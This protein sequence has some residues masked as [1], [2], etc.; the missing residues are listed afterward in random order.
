MKIVDVGSGQ[1][2]VLIP[3][4]QGRWEWMRPAVDALAAR[5]RVVTYSLA[6]EPS[7]GCACRPDDGFD[8]YVEQVSEAMDAAGLRQASICGVSYGG[9]V[10]AAFAARHPDRTSSLVLVSALPPG[11]RPDPRVR[12]YLR[13]PRLLAPL[14]ML[15]SLRLYRE[16]SAARDGIL[17]GLA[18]GVRHGFNVLAHMFSPSRMARRIAMLDAWPGRVDLRR[19]DASTLV[20][21]GEE[22]LDRVMPPARTREYLALCPDAEAVTLERT[23][24][25]GLVTRPVEFARIVS[26]FVERVT[27]AAED[28]RRVG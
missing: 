6:D 17:S 2:V 16:F 22:R 11:W 10:A 21:T 12:F 27:S 7:S 23:G 3:G 13:A 4:I 24:H 14:F 9:L 5:C 19:V 28:R 25:L 15:Q 8:R 18:E 1:P 26:S 20:I